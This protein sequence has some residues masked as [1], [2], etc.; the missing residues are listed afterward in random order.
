MRL[1]SCDKYDLASKTWD[2]L[3]WLKR[4]AEE[5]LKHRDL[6]MSIAG[7]EVVGES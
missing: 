6:G 4:F 5:P 3:F 2:I 7:W 1:T